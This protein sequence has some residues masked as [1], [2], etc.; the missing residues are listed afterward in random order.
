MEKYKNEKLNKEGL[1][2]DAHLDVIISKIELAN[3]S[4]VQI[5]RPEIKVILD[6]F[7][8]TF[9]PS[10]SDRGGFLFEEEL[11]M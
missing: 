10:G 11:T 5:N 1:S 3:R 9:K 7:N 8:K 2:Q 4:S 6:S